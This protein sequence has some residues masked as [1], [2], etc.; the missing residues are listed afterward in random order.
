MNISKQDICSIVVTFKPTKKQLNNVIFQSKNNYVFS[1]IVDNTPISKSNKFSVIE[2][3]KNFLIIK[4]NNNLGL[5][6]GL[7]QGIKKAKSLGFSFVA[8]FDQDSEIDSKFN[9]QMVK[10]INS[11]SNISK[12]AVFSPLCFDMN[13][14]KILNLNKINLLSVRRDKASFVNK[15]YE[16]DYVITSGSY[17]P[18]KMFKINGLMDDK[19]FINYID[20]IWCLKARSNKYNIA[21]FTNCKINHFIGDYSI[22]VFGTIYPIHKPIRIYYTLRNSVYCYSLDYLSFSWKL[23][24]FY[25]N[26]L[27]I[28]FY[29]IFVKNRLTY[30]RYIIKGYYHGLIKKMGKLE[31]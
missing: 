1:I 8:L 7:N 11:M 18:I 16:Q 14:K 27:R 31:E 23:I 10:N 26:I 6:F 15:V 9:D 25:R 12:Y 13:R 3:N 17:I 22:K 4:N 2:N 24:D 20:I 28:F 30:F 21:S 19:L 29:L 5:S